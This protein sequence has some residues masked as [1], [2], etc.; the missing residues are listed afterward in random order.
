MPAPGAKSPS[1]RAKRGTSATTTTTGRSTRG[2]STPSATAEPQKSSKRSAAA[3]SPAPGDL[4]VT[5]A[6]ARQ[7]ERI[8]KVD[9]DLASSPLAMTMRAL[10][11]EIDNPA[12][13]A[14]SKS[15]CAKA[16]EDIDATLRELTPAGEE[17]DALDDLARA[18][19]ARLRSSGAPA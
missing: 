16:L 3:A 9:E 17:S 14:T 11:A 10:A 19:A 12:N 2:R 4:T 7:L 5:G 13:S 15:M 6:V 18:R 8:A 1:S